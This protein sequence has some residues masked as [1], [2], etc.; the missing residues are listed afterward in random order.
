MRKRRSMGGGL[1][2][3]YGQRRLLQSSMTGDPMHLA[4]SAGGSADRPLGCLYPHSG[5]LEIKCWRFCVPGLWAESLCAMVQMPSPTAPFPRSL[6][7][8]NYGLALFLAGPSLMPV[9]L[10][11]R[12][13]SL[14]VVHFCLSKLR[15]SIARWQ[16]RVFCPNPDQPEFSPSQARHLPSSDSRC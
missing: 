4:E 3:S 6:A 10:S 12:S 11:P 13:R 9:W 2:D 16:Q 1:L 14:Q 5:R 8:W 15:G 7:L